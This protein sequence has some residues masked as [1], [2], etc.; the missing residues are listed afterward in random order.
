[1]NQPLINTSIKKKVLKEGGVLEEIKEEIKLLP[2]MVYLT[3]MT[4]A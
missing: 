2:E 4:D 1:M 3:G